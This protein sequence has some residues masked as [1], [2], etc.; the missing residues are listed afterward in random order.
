MNDAATTTEPAQPAQP[1]KIAQLA[2]LLDQARLERSE[3]SPLSKTH[4]AFG[5]EE[6]YRIL[7]AGIALRTARGERVVGCKMGL[8]SQAKREQMNLGSPIYGML[9]DAMRVPDGATFSLGRSLHAKVEP[10]IAFI[11]AR[12]LSGPVTRAEALA[13]CSGVCAALEVIDSRFVGFKYFSLPDVV[14]DDCSASHFV[15]GAAPIDPASL[16]QTGLGDLPM[17]L[18]VDGKLVQSARSSE[19]SGHP[20]ESLVQLCAMLSAH[21][22]SLPA[23]SIVMAGA[24][25]VAVQLLPGMEIL[26]EIDGLGTVS[27]RTQ[28]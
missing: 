19:I 4:G 23:G 25:T 15:L 7:H 16:G 26:L 6:A 1:E 18:S 13:A 24:A 27:L 3:L 22:H 11:T 10:E 9:T 28:P 14:A 12:E 20:V 5:L 21:G 8:T 17:R 2:Q